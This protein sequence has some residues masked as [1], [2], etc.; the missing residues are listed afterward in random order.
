MVGHSVKF[1]R[2]GGEEPQLTVCDWLYT[3][4]VEQPAQ[5]DAARWDDGVCHLGRGG[6]GAG[7]LG[8]LYSDRTLCGHGECCERERAVRQGFF[9][10]AWLMG[11]GFCWLFG[12]GC[13]MGQKSATGGIAMQQVLNSA[14]ME[15]SLL[16]WCFN[17]F[18]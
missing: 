13:E 10:H 17:P 14:K 2:N 11:R 6:G 9:S 5:G 8:L 3:G 15:L 4:Q 12:G 16:F 7:L 18:P 1:Q